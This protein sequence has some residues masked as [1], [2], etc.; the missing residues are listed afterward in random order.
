MKTS[1][2]NELSNREIEILALV[3]MGLF[4]QEIAKQNFLSPHTVRQDLKNIYKKIG[5]RNRVEASLK[6]LFF[7]QPV[8][9]Y[10]TA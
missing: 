3:S 10:G 9:I 7:F 5:V 1:L 2:S 4:D 8:S 6:Y